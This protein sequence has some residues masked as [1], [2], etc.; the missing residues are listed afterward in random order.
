VKRVLYL[1]GVVV[2]IFVSSAE[3]SPNTCSWK[4][5]KL[6]I[7]QGVFVD[8]MG[9]PIKE[10]TIRLWNDGFKT[11]LISE[12]QADELGR[13]RLARVK[14]GSYFLEFQAPGYHNS[15]A[16][17]RV[18]GYASSATGLVIVPPLG[19]MGCETRI[20]KRRLSINQRLPTN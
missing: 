17:I 16:E 12:G 11:N 6:K 5:P 15:Q 3:C 8:L 2:C 13:F 9:T 4:P 18:T 1:L 19:A 14:S 10:T 7:V 20:Q